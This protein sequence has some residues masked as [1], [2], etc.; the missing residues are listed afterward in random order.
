MKK[1]RLIITGILSILFLVN[2]VL[3]E[4]VINIGVE[5]CKSNEVDLKEVSIIDGIKTE[6]EDSGDYTLYLLGYK[7]NV[8]H[9]HN[10]KID[11]VLYFDPPIFVDCMSKVFKL[12]YSED[13]SSIKLTK[14]ENTLLE[15][16]IKICDLDDACE[17]YENYISCPQDCSSGSSDG[18]CDK[19]FDKICDPDC[20]RDVD[21]DCLCGD[22]KCEVIKGESY[23]T[24]PQDCTSGS[25]DGYC[26]GVSDGKCDPDCLVTE[27]PDCKHVLGLEKGKEDSNMR[28][29]IGALI[30]ILII[31]VGVLIV[32]RRGKE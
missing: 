7:G 19:V 17:G 15:K 2:C 29:L 9:K 11:F 24:C 16:E 6:Y 12:P 27:D 18:Y 30:L 23:K 5:I 4:K 26:D 21:V 28:I 20:A 31:I 13:F 32:N 10:F 14:N 8:L 1:G 3:A 25:L 22:N